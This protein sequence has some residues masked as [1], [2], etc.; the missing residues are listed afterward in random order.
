[1]NEIETELDIDIDDFILGMFRTSS[2]PPFSFR[3]NFMQSMTEVTLS[4]FL[5]YV[6]LTGAS[7]RYNKQLH[8]LTEN[9]IGRLR[10]YLLSFG[11]DADYHMVTLQNEVLDYHPDGLPYIRFLKLNNWQITFKVADPALNRINDHVAH[12]AYQP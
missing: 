12:H 9:E 8:E 2:M 10:E 1:M 4:S 6:L 11:W 7:T 3:F 5:S